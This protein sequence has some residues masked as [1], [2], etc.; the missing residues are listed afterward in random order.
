[1]MGVLKSSLSK[2]P[3]GLADSLELYARTWNVS[4]GLWQTNRDFPFNPDGFSERTSGR[5]EKI[6]DD[7]NKAKRLLAAPLYELSEKLAAGE[8]VRD[9]AVA[10]YEY[11]DLLSVEKKLDELAAGGL[12]Q[13]VVAVAA[14]KEYCEVADI[15]AAAKEKDEKPFIII[16][17]NIT[18]PHNLG[19]IIRTACCA[20]AHGVIIPKRGG[21]G[22]NSTVYKTSAGA[23]EYMPVAKVNSISNA[24]G[25]L[26]ANG[27]WIY[28]TDASGE[29]NYTECDLNGSIALVIGSEGEG[30]KKHTVS[31]CDFLVKIP[32]KGKINS[33]NASAAAAVMI[34][35]ALRQ[36]D[37]K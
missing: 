13:G 7:A 5:G 33:L 22:V 17:E 25:E 37:A 19:A 4:G 27:V 9:H 35:E 3:E 2:V 10:L 16:C 1:M 20:G 32:L 12:H 26:K 11:L 6:L 21:V 18:D 14:M 15:L 34:Y 28:G 8:C 24:I 29:Q 23:A 30:M 31:Q 36:R